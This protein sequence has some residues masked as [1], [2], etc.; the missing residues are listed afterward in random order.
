MTTSME[1]SYDIYRVRTVAEYFS[2]EKEKNWGSFKRI[3]KE[4]K[5]GEIPHQEIGSIDFIYGALKKLKE[6][7]LHKDINA[8]KALMDIFPKGKMVPENSLQ[9]GLFYYYKYQWAAIEILDAMDENYLMP[10]EEMVQLVIAIFG[11]YSKPIAKLGRMIYWYS[12]ARYNDPYPMPTHLPE[13]P[14]ELAIIG[15]R[16]MSVDLNTKISVFSVCF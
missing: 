12:K 5:A 4:Y 13:S 7:G 6:F 15:L 14:K 11:E 3:I 8:Y 1:T 10:D 9:R 16:R 2:K